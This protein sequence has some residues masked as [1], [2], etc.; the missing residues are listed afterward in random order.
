MLGRNIFARYSH[1]PDQQTILSSDKDIVVCANPRVAKDD[2]KS[3]SGYS[4][5]SQAN[6][7]NDYRYSDENFNAPHQIQA[8]FTDDPFQNVG[9][10]D[11][12]LL[13][14]GLKPLQILNSV[15]AT[16]FYSFHLVRV[17][18]TSHSSAVK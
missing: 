6:D 8:F 13:R 5:K 4:N 2:Q 7:A 9:V 1:S 3:W 16:L 12:T 11:S 17:Y 18:C 15:I 14:D 10:H